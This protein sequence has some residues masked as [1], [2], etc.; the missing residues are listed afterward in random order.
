MTVLRFSE[1]TQEEQRGGLP[2]GTEFD[3]DYERG[4]HAV[5]RIDDYGNF[6]GLDSDGVLC[7]FSVD[8]VAATWLD[9]TINVSHVVVP[10]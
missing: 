7:L 9:S 10:A 5:T 6:Y 3:T 8:M 2:A 4:C 1:W